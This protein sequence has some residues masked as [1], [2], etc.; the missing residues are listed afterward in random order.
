MGSSISLYFLIFRQTGELTFKSDFNFKFNDAFEFIK[1]DLGDKA[2]Q[3]LRPENADNG[4]KQE[5]ANVI[6]F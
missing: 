6:L 3:L 1:N 5:I 4:D 2:V